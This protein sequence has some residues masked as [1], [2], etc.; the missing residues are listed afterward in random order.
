MIPVLLCGA[1]SAKNLGSSD[2]P[3]A[4]PLNPEDL[5]NFLA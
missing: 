4:L 3:L 2:A 5:Y 1:C